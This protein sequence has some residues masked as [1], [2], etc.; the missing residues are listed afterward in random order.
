MNISDSPAA[1]LFVDLAAR[2]GHYCPMSTLGLRLGWAALRRLKSELQGATYF[3]QT[4][5]RDGIRLALNVD[6]LQV[7]GEGRHLLR[8]FDKD[9]HWQIELLPKA[10]ELAA[11]Y[12]SLAG[13]AERDSLL[14]ELR[15]AD[16]S[17][18]LR[19][20]PGGGPS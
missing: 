19:I 7:E 12:R 20:V 3:A 18:L 10:L 13:D 1:Q 17:S 9:A 11:T 14:E 16:E 2:H 15:S 4:C 8:F 5:A 6:S